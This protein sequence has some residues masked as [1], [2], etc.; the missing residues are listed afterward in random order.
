MSNPKYR[1]SMRVVEQSGP[2]SGMVTFTVAAWF[3]SFIARYDE[4]GIV[5]IISNECGDDASGM[6]AY[7]I[8]SVIADH[9][10]RAMFKAE[11]S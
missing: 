11:T 4:N 8:Q 6:E 10:C 2:V 3:G 7:E 9:L 5:D 1:Y